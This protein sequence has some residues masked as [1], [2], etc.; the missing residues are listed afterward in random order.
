L[1]TNSCRGWDFEELRIVW[2]VWNFG[3]EDWKLFGII[4]S[5]GDALSGAFGY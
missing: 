4:R 5:G 2:Q 3:F 1:I